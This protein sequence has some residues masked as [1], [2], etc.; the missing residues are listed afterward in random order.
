MLNTYIIYKNLQ[1]Q[2]IKN[3]KNNIEIDVKQIK[4]TSFEITYDE[5]LMLI[6]KG[7]LAVRNLLPV[8]I[9]S[10]NL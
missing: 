1:Q 10:F 4:T 9:K 2:I 6:Q 8:L 5:K 7:R 3:H